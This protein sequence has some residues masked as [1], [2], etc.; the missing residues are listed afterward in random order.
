MVQLGA[1]SRFIHH[2]KYCRKKEDVAESLYDTYI[3]KKEK[4]LTNS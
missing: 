1:I 4:A 3:H 2:Q